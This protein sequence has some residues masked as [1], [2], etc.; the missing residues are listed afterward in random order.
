M[1][2]ED[3]ATDRLVPSETANNQP[4]SEDDDGRI[5]GFRQP[6][7]S[8]PTHRDKTARALAL[9]SFLVLCVVFGVHYASIFYLAMKNRPDAIEH[10]NR[11]FS[12]WIPIFSGLVGSAATFY[13]T[14]DRR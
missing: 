12:T 5:T 8:A 13:F 7:V 4:G 10:V 1:E 3:D 9:A 6:I 2:M 11:I 14:R